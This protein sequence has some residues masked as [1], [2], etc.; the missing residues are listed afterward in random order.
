ML[1]YRVLYQTSAVC[2]PEMCSVN[3]TLMPACGLQVRKSQCTCMWNMYC[4]SVCHSAVC[5]TCTVLVCVT[6]QYVEHVLS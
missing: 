4:P 6:L 3:D 1:K 5:G 2:S